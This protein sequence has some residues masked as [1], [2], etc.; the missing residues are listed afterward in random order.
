MGLRVS[1]RCFL[2]YT[3]WLIMYSRI[4]QERSTGYKN[5]S[6]RMPN[7]YFGPPFGGSTFAHECRLFGRRYVPL[8]CPPASLL[9]AL[10]ASHYLPALS[11]PLHPSVPWIVGSARP[12]PA[13][14]GRSSFSVL[15]PPISLHRVSSRMG[16][17]SPFHL[18]R[19]PSVYA[20]AAAMVAIWHKLQRQT[21]NNGFLPPGPER[22]SERASGRTGEQRAKTA[23]SLP[24]PSLIL[25]LLLYR[26][27][28]FAPSS[29]ALGS[30]HSVAA[31]RFEMCVQWKECPF[32]ANPLK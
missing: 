21:P 14:L 15:I 18:S 16:N 28:L 31:I 30:S 29:S 27:F 26:P 19:P 13:C 11:P 7:Y 20:A 22:A 6:I 4:T 32:H 23:P 10:M 5:K 12:C 24:P 2:P 8:P 1:K 25:F 9:P 17:H 3:T